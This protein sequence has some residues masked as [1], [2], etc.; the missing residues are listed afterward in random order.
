MF[1]KRQRAKYLEPINE[2]D[3]EDDDEDEGDD[4]NVEEKRTIQNYI[5][6]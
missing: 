1:F 6:E 3:E 4:E 2:N 5:F